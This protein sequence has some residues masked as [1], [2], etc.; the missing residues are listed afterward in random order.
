MKNGVKI[1]ETKFYTTPNGVVICELECDMQLYKHPSYYYIND[2]MWKPKFP[3]VNYKGEFTV[4][5]KARC[6]STDT[7]D[8]RRGKMIAES[9]AKAKMFGIAERVY[10]ECSKALYKVSV[11]CATSKAACAEARDGEETH[12]KELCV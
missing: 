9:R 2:R 4:R 8:E 6:H 11:T 3:K 7:Y 10:E 12:V 1:T 5:A